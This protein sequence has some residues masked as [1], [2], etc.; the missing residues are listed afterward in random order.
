MAWRVA[1]VAVRG[2]DFGAARELARR[3]RDVAEV[4]GRTHTAARVTVT[5]AGIEV[6]AGNHDEARRMLEAALVSADSVGRGEARSQ[7]GLLEMLAGD[8]TAAIRSFDRALPAL[9]PHG[10][11]AANTL[12]NRGI[13]HAYSGDLRRARHDLT[14]AIRVFES[15]EAHRAVAEL[16][17][18][19]GW[20]MDQEGDYVGALQAFTEAETI[21]RT[22]AASYGYLLR[23]RATTLIAVGLA[24]EAADQAAES[25]DAFEDAGRHGDAA[26]S[27]AVQAMALLATGRR[28]EAAQVAERAEREFRE[29]GRPIH[30]DHAALVGLKAKPTNTL[31][32]TDA[33]KAREL[34]ARLDR[35]AAKLVALD[36]AVTAA[37][38][39]LAVGDR[40][41]ADRL[42]A[43]A[44]EA[45]ASS[46]P[47]LRLAYWQVIADLRAD[48][49]D[50]TGVLRAARAGM[51]VVERSQRLLGST[52]ARVNVAAG[53]DR[54]GRT[55]L[56]AARQGGAGQLFDWMER[57]RAGSLRFR[58]VRPDHSRTASQ[59]AAL[60]AIALEIEQAQLE[61]EDTA[62]PRHRQANLERSLRLS[63]LETRGEGD[64]SRRVTAADVRE[65]LGERVMVSYAEIGGRLHAVRL[66]RRRSRSFDLG[67]IQQI[68]DELDHL[69]FALLRVATGRVSVG[70][71]DLLATGTS[72]LDSM[73][74]APVVGGGDEVIIV[75]TGR[76]FPAPWSLLPSARERV[77]V[78]APSASLWMAGRRR[79]RKTGTVVLAA[80]PDLEHSGAEVR[81]LGRLHPAAHVL[82][83]ATATVSGVLDAADGADLLHVACHGVF[84][85]DNP[86]FSSLKL[87]D[88]PLTVH[89]L[90]TLDR[91]PT[92]V[93][94]SACD[95]GLAEPRPGNEWMGM[96]AALLTL[97]TRSL[98][99]SV[100]AVPDAGPTL[101][102][103]D[104]LHRRLL[105]RSDVP[106][107]LAAAI[108]Q[109]PD[110][111]ETLATRAAFVCMGG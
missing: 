59:Q 101:D 34:A 21:L 83:P 53:A 31:D 24:E 20:V 95:S 69:R 105:A 65:E 22:P 82:T 51:D 6:L 36:A 61:G 26:E 62:G 58:P 38:I 25:A 2:R 89:E 88:G 17:Q 55:A 4:A 66:D 52:E 11:W 77:A 68:H 5:L 99:A 100:V 85:Y 29:Q 37:R 19:L 91:A 33:R 64:A 74:L 42:L 14:A 93:V 81:R 109:L 102:L 49:G 71:L 92:T 28:G 47:D 60:R 43:G 70:T 39:H 30:A 23:D 32:P 75:P 45:R 7:L 9:D 94:L 15:L 67:P 57:V 106:E 110:E 46:R 41:R 86:L 8:H 18:N 79:R 63:L 35:T 54:L 1:A 72:R 3:G 90:E 76:L 16:R 78:L 87:A 48:S 10:A 80:G 84:R 108:R 40:R 96:A 56:A 104:A 97:G 103:M 73:V 13:T 111:P 98:V 44:V 107:A 12:S 50:R 27:W